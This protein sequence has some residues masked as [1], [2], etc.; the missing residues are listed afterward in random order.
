MCRERFNVARGLDLPPRV[1]QLSCRRRRIL[2]ILLMFE[3]LLSC[4][5]QGNGTPD[6]YKILGD[7]RTG[8]ANYDSSYM[9]NN[10]YENQ[11]ELY[12]GRSGDPWS[13]SSVRFYNKNIYTR[14]SLNMTTNNTK[15]QSAIDL[16]KSTE[17][18]RFKRGVIHLY[19]MVVCATGC[20]PLAYKG[21]GC[22]CG[23]L[24]SGYVI[25]GIDQCCK[26]HDWCY[27]AT[28][29]LM[30]SEYFVP[31]YWRCY[32]GSKPICGSFIDRLSVCN[33]SFEPT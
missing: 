23:F 22:Y 6:V 14:I 18:A 8:Q 24:G 28:E 13:T 29:C 25:D 32:H 3:T 12:I 15:T 16:K 19:N 30:F 31:Y 10:M 7:T 26:M 21:Y 20:N 27:D 9:N 5:A 4:D 11:E 2:C 17:H 33:F 1:N